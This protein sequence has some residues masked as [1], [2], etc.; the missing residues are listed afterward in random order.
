MPYAAQHGNTA[1]K[2]NIIKYR[3]EHEP[4]EHEN[5]QT[6]RCTPAR[7]TQFCEKAQ[8][9]M[10]L[11]CIEHKKCTRVLHNLQ[12]PRILECGNMF[13]GMTTKGA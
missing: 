10:M 3:P 7:I 1:R 6:G 4:F 12:H 5:K 8:N 2:D 11:G 9:A 13:T